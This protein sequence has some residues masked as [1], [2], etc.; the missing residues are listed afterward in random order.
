MRKIF[1]AS[2]ALLLSAGAASAD[3][4]GVTINSSLAKT[5]ALSTIA[6]VTLNAN[7]TASSVP[8][9]HNCNFSVAPVTVTFQSA[10]GAV[11]NSVES[12]TKDYNVTF[13]GVTNAASTI[14]V[15]AVQFGA[16]LQASTATS[17]DVALVSALT[18]GGSYTDT[19]TISVTP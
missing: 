10:A 5:C 19:L 16:P 1:L 17:F 13:N 11:V 14:K 6:P 7:A 15:S 18:V 12:V 9:V 4:K 8:F 3:S 2:A